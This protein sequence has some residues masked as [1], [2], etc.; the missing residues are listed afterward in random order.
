MI[1]ETIKRLDHLLKTL[2]PLLN[3]VPENEFRNKPKPEKW[4]KQEIL[5]HLI[6]S[7]ANNHQRFIRIQFEKDPRIIY[8]QDE[9]VKHNHYNDLDKD[10]VIRFWTLYNTHILEVI[11]RVPDSNLLRTSYTNGPEKLTLG[12]LINDYLVHLE[13]H[14]KQIVDFPTNVTVYPAK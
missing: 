10:H 9:C 11:K 14:M 12:W 7:A 5:G 3:V 13:Y 8:E 1:Q 6:D 4:S 2:P